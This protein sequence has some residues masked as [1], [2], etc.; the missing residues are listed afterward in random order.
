M[1]A[2]VRAGRQSVL[3][4]D[5][6]LRHRPAA[7]APLVPGLWAAVCESARFC[8]NLVQVVDLGG[9]KHLVD[10]GL[11][12]RA[13][14]LCAG[15]PAPRPAGFEKRLRYATQVR[16]AAF[17]ALEALAS[18][19]GRWGGAIADFVEGHA[20]AFLEAVGLGLTRCAV[21]GE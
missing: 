16:K 19:A 12:V 3:L 2:C 7:I 11:G 17:E 10:R 14:H 13:A 15:Q 20:E 1:R 18:E 21:K 4:L 5:A 6:A 8:S 9:M